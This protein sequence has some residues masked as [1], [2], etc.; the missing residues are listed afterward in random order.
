MSGAVWLLQ[1]DSLPNGSVDGLGAA[2]NVMAIASMEDLSVF[3][4]HCFE[5]VYASHCLEHAGWQVH[6]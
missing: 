1:V 5:V 2:S 3:S 6:V 4:N